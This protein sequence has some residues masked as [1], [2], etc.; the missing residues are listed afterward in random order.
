MCS[1]CLILVVIIGCI[2]TAGFFVYG[3]K[4]EWRP[5]RLSDCDVCIHLTSTGVC[6]PA[7]RWRHR[8]GWPFMF[9]IWNRV[10]I[11]VQTDLWPFQLS[12]HQRI[13]DVYSSLFLHV[14][15][16][17]SARTF[18]S[19]CRIRVCRFHVFFFVYWSFCI[20]SVVRLS[21]SELLRVFSGVSNSLLLLLLLFFIDIVT[22]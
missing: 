4:L 13:S 22:L 6:G 2:L 21:Y 20:R 1:Y 9:N 3:A 12:R 10:V 16:P 19:T 8:R 17:I 18:F 5:S 11:E 7:Y 15:Q 14:Q